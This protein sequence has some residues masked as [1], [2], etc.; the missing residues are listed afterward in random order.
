MKKV[1]F[2]TL[3]SFLLGCS[4][5]AAGQF[6]VPVPAPDDEVTTSGPDTKFSLVTQMRY[7]AFENLESQLTVEIPEDR[8]VV[9]IF[10]LSQ[11][12]KYVEKIKIPNTKIIEYTNGTY[13][14]KFKDT[15]YVIYNYD[16]QGNL[17][18][19]IVQTNKAKVPFVSYHYDTYGQIKAVEVKPD[20]YHSYIYDLNGVLLKYV[21]YNKVY[22]PNGKLVLKRKSNFI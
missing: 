2:L 18:E 22:L 19:V 7:D 14:I 11:N 9:A 12:E 15:P 21:V 10:K 4:V 8:K 17:Q 1:L 20:F 3:L 16:K 6:D 5:F 13:D